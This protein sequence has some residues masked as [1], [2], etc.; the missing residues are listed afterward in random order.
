MCDGPQKYE[1]WL[2]ESQDQQQGQGKN[3]EKGG[4]NLLKHDDVNPKIRLKTQEEDK[5]EPAEEDAE[6]SK[7]PP[8]PC[9]AHEV[10]IGY[11]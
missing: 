2:S 1:K 9:Q 3:L 7:L 8:P 10:A 11:E 5:I 6:R 4:Y